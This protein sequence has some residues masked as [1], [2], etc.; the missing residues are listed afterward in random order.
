M[1][2]LIKKTIK[3]KY[4]FA[5]FNLYVKPVCLYIRQFLNLFCFLNHIIQ[6]YLV[7]KFKKFLCRND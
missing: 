5:I 2:K 7:N 1:T 4:K 3:Y 6:I